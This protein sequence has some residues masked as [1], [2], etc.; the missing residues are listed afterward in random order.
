M[1]SHVAVIF[2][3]LWTLLSFFQ[4]FYYGKV[5]EKAGSMSS[6]GDKL[7]AFIKG[8]GWFP[9]TPRLGDP[10]GVPEV[11]LD[12]LTTPSIKKLY[13]VCAL[14]ISYSIIRHLNHRQPLFSMNATGREDRW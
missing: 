2:S 8:P 7:C 3:I 10:L 4:S 5:F 13:M 9:G 12:Q 1:Y 14:Y 11:I 6:F